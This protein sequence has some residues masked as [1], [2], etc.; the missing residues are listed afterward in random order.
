M[1][2]RPVSLSPVS[3]WNGPYSPKG[4]KKLAKT[5]N[6]DMAKLTRLVHALTGFIEALTKLVR[7]LSVLAKDPIVALWLTILASQ[8]FA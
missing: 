3:C 8:I 6:K 1:T 2:L 4:Q 7:A 5:V